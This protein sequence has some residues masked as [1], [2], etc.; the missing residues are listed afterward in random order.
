MMVALAL[1]R[2][3]SSRGLSMIGRRGSDYLSGLFS[4]EGQDI[5]RE[6]PNSFFI[7]VIGMQIPIR[8]C[9]CFVIPTAFLGLLRRTT[10][11]VNHRSGAVQD[12]GNFTQEFGNFIQTGNGRTGHV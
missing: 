9:D 1:A 12:V 8:A 10:H 7:P 5:V 2:R 3:S 6:K 11:V 4:R